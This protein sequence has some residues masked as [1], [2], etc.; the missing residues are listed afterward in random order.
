MRIKRDAQ[1]SDGT[2]RLNLSP[3]QNLCKIEHFPQHASSHC[4]H[5]RLR[6]VEFRPMN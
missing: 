3:A 5:L 4:Y 2:R 6:L 1:I